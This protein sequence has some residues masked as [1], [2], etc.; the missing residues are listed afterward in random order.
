M[1]A[2]SKNDVVMCKQFVKHYV[3][4]YYCIN[5]SIEHTRKDLI[6]FGGLALRVA[7]TGEGERGRAE[8][9]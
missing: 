3:G 5:M 8:C 1:V 7:L 6:K 9:C 4:Y 2:T